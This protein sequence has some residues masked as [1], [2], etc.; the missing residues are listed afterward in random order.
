MNPSDVL[1][2]AV[3]V[4]CWSA[5]VAYPALPVVSTTQYSP[6]AMFDIVHTPDAEVVQV[7]VVAASSPPCGAA[8]ASG[9]LSV[10][11]VNTTPLRLLAGLAS[12]VLVMVNDPSL[13]LV[14]VQVTS[15]P[16]D[17]VTPIVL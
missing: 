4:T 12:S 17:S 1:D 8:P 14:K 9:A 3:T 16:A 15:S 13:V 7:V 5:A 6:S 11:S 2:P 10:Y